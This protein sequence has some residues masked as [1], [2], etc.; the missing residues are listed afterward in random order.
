ML[1][2]V[3]LVGEEFFMFFEVGGGE[4]V[5]EEEVDGVIEIGI[6]FYVEVFEGVGLYEVLYGVEEKFVGEDWV[7]VVVY[8]VVELVFFDE[9]IED[10]GE[11]FGVGVEDVVVECGGV[12][13]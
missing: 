1:E 2:V 3:S 13:F 7:D 12:L 8:G 11:V 5:V 4:E 10:V 9:E 6:G